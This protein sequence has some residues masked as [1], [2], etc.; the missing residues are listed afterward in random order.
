MKCL[1]P[2]GPG[3]RSWGGCELKLPWDSADEEVI[4]VFGYGGAVR[5]AGRLRDAFVE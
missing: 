4:D 2:S 3:R 5:A 1:L